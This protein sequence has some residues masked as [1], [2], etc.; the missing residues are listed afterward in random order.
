MGLLDTY[1]KSATFDRVGDRVGGRVIGAPREVQQK[2]YDSGKPLWWTAEGG[3]PSTDPEERDGTKRNPVMQLVVTVDT[4]RIDPAVEDDDGERA[5]WVRGQ[6]LQA[7]RAALKRVRAKHIEP[8]GEFWVVFEREEQGR[9]ERGRA[10]GNPKKIY[11]V[12]YAPPDDEP[13]AD[14]RPQGHQESLKAAVAARGTRASA[15]DAPPF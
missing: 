10:K 4:G 14:D 1:A 8:G 13:P 3:R 12:T 15:D 2:D 5:V 9:D 11:A 6:M 7:A